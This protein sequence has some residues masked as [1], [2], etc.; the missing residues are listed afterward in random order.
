M[1]L[2]AFITAWTGREA[3]NNHGLFKG[4]CV[5]LAAQF[6]QNVLVIPNADGVLYCSKTG[7]A[8]DLYEQFDGQLPTYF[9]RVPA[10]QSPLV[11]DLVVWGASMGQYGDVAI[12]AGNNQVFGQ[13]GTPVFQP[14]RLRTMNPGYLGF[15]RKKGVPMDDNLAADIGTTLYWSVYHRD[16]ESRQA[17]MVMGHKLD[18]IDQPALT[19]LDAMLKGEM[20][21]PEWQ[22]D[23]Q[24]LKAPAPAQPTALKP[25]T[26]IVN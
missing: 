7:G 4:E 12:Y 5:S 25:G 2:D 16:P 20:K 21:S 23:D 22:A 18:G 24:K 10:S 13:L 9:D 6:C 15:L 26:Y 19:R 1:T 11:G 17:A 3:P 14:A 8:R